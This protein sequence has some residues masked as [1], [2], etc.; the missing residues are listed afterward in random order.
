MV[1]CTKI[2][3]W[4]AAAFEAFAENPIL[5]F[6]WQ[7]GR[8]QTLLPWPT[9]AAMNTNLEI[10]CR[11]SHTSPARTALFSRSWLQLRS[12][13]TD[14]LPISCAHLAAQPLPHSL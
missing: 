2:G 11:C 6:R 12:Q 7:H 10:S 5:K 1:H 4:A 3:Q 13:A 14:G 8:L 9:R